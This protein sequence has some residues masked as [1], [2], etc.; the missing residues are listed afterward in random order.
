MEVAMEATLVGARC[1]T[2]LGWYDE[3][4]SGDSLGTR[5]GSLFTV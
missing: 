1:A 3:Q 2:L 5:S 4:P